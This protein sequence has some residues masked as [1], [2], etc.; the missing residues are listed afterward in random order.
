MKNS[1]KIIL[2]LGMLLITGL[3][4]ASDNSLNE[5]LMKA[6]DQGQYDEA[7]LALEQ[8]ADPS[9]VQNIS[10]ITPLIEA[11]QKDR[12][13]LVTLLLA[14]GA[15]I[16]Y[17][18]HQTGNTALMFAVHYLKVNVIPVLL[19]ANVNPHLKNSAG[20]SALDIAKGQYPPRIMIIS[21]LRYG[22]KQTF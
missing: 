18:T 9:Y 22:N 2:V 19:Q 6:V 4:H 3:Q 16:N 10:K 20:R 15:N 17:Q 14:H 7:K 11:V 5:R 13:D 21:Y 12:A 8:G 1:L